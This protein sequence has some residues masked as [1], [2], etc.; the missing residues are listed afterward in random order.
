MNLKWEFLMRKIFG[1]F[2]NDGQMIQRFGDY[3]GFV[4]ND[5][6]TDKRLLEVKSVTSYAFLSLNAILSN[7]NNEFYDEFGTNY[8]L[9]EVFEAENIDTIDKLIEIYD[10]KVFKPNLQ[11]I[12]DK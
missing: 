11:F 1:I 2:S 3:S 5:M 7:K 6:F 4:D 9:R 8:L 12:K 10:E